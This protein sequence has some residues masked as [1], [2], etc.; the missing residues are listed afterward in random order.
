MT[1]KDAELAREVVREDGFMYSVRLDESGDDGGSAF[2]NSFA[3]FID[4]L[5]NGDRRLV[6]TMYKPTVLIRGPIAMVWAAYDF[7]IDQEFSHC[8]IDIFTLIKS[9]G[10]WKLAGAVYTIEKTEC[11]NVKSGF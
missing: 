3:N 2:L 10:S 4:G 1:E 9:G 11:E 7:Y 6:E 8:G 5:E